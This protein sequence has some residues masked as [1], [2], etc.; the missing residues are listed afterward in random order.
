[1]E[2]ICVNKLRKSYG[3]EPIQ[4]KE[5]NTVYC[6]LDLSSQKDLT[7]TVTINPRGSKNLCG[8][9]AGDR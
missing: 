3:L 2:T 5:A 1:M 9:L 7:V 4:S 8:K 6:G